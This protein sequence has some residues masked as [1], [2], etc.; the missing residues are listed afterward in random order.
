MGLFKSIY[1]AIVS[2]KTGKTSGSVPFINRVVI[3]RRCRK[4]ADGYTG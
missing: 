1:T 3:W 2:R 4:N